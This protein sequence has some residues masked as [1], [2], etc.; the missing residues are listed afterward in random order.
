MSRLKKIRQEYCQRIADGEQ[1]ENVN[2][3][4]LI[5]GRCAKKMIHGQLPKFK[6]DLYIW[7]EKTFTFN[8]TELPLPESKAPNINQKYYVFD[9]RRETGLSCYSWMGD[10]W[11]NFCLRNG[12]I[13]LKKQDLEEVVKAFKKLAK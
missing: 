13:Y 1:P 2:A 5:S 3:D 11:D 8:N 12:T 10:P 9:P 4:L 7:K 6:A